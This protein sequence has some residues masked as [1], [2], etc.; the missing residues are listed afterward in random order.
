MVQQPQ[1]NWKI[2]KAK[3]KLVFPQLTND[4][5]HFDEGHKYQ[6]LDNLQAKLGITPSALEVIAL[7]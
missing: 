1:S 5:L 7:A 2:Q 6:M 3:L 4:D